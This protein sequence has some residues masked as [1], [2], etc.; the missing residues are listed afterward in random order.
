MDHN[1]AI[2]R[3]IEGSMSGDQ[4]AA[5]MDRLI[6]GTIKWAVQ[7]EDRNTFKTNFQSGADLNRMLEWGHGA[8]KG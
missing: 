6:P 4:V 8:N 1:A 7:E 2:I 3:V 5:E